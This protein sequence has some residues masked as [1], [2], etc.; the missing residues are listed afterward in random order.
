MP[1]FTEIV[2]WDSTQDLRDNLVY[3]L[4]RPSLNNIEI[5]PEGLTNGPSSRIGSAT[6]R[7]DYGRPGTT[8]ELS[9]DGSPLLKFRVKAADSAQ[10][11]ASS[12]YLGTEVDRFG[13][14]AIDTVKYTTV[15]NAY[16][17]VQE[18]GGINFSGI[19]SS[20][21]DVF[22]SPALLVLNTPLVDT[23]GIRAS[24]RM[25]ADPNSL[26][27]SGSITALE[28]DNGMHNVQVQKYLAQIRANIVDTSGNTTGRQVDSNNIAVGEDIAVEVDS[29]DTGV[30]P[31]LSD[32]FV[33]SI[34]D[35]IS[36][37]VQVDEIQDLKGVED[38]VDFF[39]RQSLDNSCVRVLGVRAD[40]SVTGVLS[41]LQEGLFY[42]PKRIH[43]H[44]AMQIPFVNP[45]VDLFANTIQ[46]F[47]IVNQ[48]QVFAEVNDTWT[49]TILVPSGNHR[50]LFE[51]DGQLIVDPENPNTTETASGTQSTLTTQ[52]TQFIEFALQ[53]AA[54]QVNL[55]LFPN[56]RERRTH[57]MSVG[58]DPSEILKISTV[59]ETYY[60]AH[61]DWH[62]VDIVL[63]YPTPV[64]KIRFLTD[65]PLSHKQRVR[66]LLDD[67]PIQKEEW[68]LG[69]APVDSESI[70]ISECATYDNQLQSTFNPECISYFDNN[71]D[72]I[73]A[74]ED[75]FVEWTY[76]AD[77]E[78]IVNRPPYVVRKISLLTRLEN[79][80]TYQRAHRAFEIETP[81]THVA[82]VTDFIVSDN[83]ALFRRARTTVVGPLGDWSIQ[84]AVL[85]GGQN[86]L[87]PQ[88]Q[89]LESMTYGSSVIATQEPVKS[90]IE[91]LNQ[92]GI[93]LNNVEVGCTLQG[94][95]TQELQQ[96]TQVVDTGTSAGGPTPTEPRF[97][98]ESF[99]RASDR[100]RAIVINISIVPE[101]TYYIHLIAQPMNYMLEL[102]E[103]LEE[104]RTRTNRLGSATSSGYGFQSISPFVADRQIE[105]PS[106]LVDVEVTNILACFDEEAANAILETQPRA[107]T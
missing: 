14:T 9:F 88:Q 11:L 15:P 17:I 37:P 25:R 72:V 23:Y 48:E 104:A 100:L 8:T 47:N 94:Q 49:T 81:A 28:L 95:L 6:Y 66:I 57:E 86:L 64:S 12:E 16:S 36:D 44:F 33:G 54:Q 13:G 69:C 83:E 80:R 89:L 24:L 74:S 19:Q 4:S 78:P 82:P 71:T 106:G 53:R 18:G 50:Y 101:N 99:T 51:V 46:S 20:T 10:E 2:R 60:N 87:L 38:V 45:K 98:R 63:D 56:G 70:G 65:I 107:N 40:Y 21:N 7:Y 96:V 1:D 34:V 35:Q 102:Y 27:N 43:N 84:Q 5:L 31:A 32:G 58:F 91:G 52:S 90:F 75:Q 92:S 105:T 3:G 62:R 61:P 93:A 55:V 97:T 26:V 77:Q 68:E 39:G 59:D 67:I 22:A 41:D 103:T 30:Q 79:G 73:T 42:K 29:V 76:I 85:N